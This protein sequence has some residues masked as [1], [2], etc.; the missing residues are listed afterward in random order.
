MAQYIYSIL[1]SQVNIMWSWG[2]NS[3]MALTDGLQFNPHCSLCREKIEKT[4]KKQLFSG[5]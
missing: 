3:P 5:Q 2:F 1:K 4:G